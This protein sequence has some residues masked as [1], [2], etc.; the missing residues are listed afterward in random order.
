MRVLMVL[1][2]VGLLLL[3]GGALLVLCLS[4]GRDA[5][6]TTRSL[7]PLA[8]E[9][10]E[11]TFKPFLV[12]QPL[13]ELSKDENATV[14]AMVRK[15]VHYLKRTQTA[16]GTWAHE[17]DNYVPFAGLTLLEC[18]VSSDDPAIVRAADYA[19]GRAAH[20]NHTYAASLF[21]LFFDRLGDPRDNE[22]I[23]DLAMRL[24]AGQTGQGGWGYDVP[25]LSATESA[26]LRTFL[27]DSGR[28]TEATAR[29]AAA[30][31]SLKVPSRLRRL[32]LWHTSN[33]PNAEYFR[34]GG[35]NSNTQFALLALWAA[36]RHK[37]PV[38]PSLDLV[39]RRFRNS[40]NPDGS[41]PYEG[42]RF[43]SELPSMTCA[44]LLGLAV[45]YGLMEKSDVSGPQHDA[46]IQKALER[47][48]QA[49]GR[50]ANSPQ[51]SM[52]MTEMYFLWSLERVAVLYQ[53]KKIVDK[54]W[55]RWGFTML[56]KNQQGDGSW[57]AH[58]GHGTNPLVDTC[59]A[60]LF[61][62][63]A[64]LV[65]DLTDKLATLNASATLNSDAP[66]KDHP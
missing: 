33:N 2:S 56:R 55:Y 35:D 50:P 45:D 25:I 19:R 40:Q 7:S 20:I 22:R 26:A 29:R 16:E 60:L 17:P 62:Q 63:R 44:G 53:L 23:A 10:P 32:G 11:P 57:H 28:R 59:F 64:N 66:R 13:I 46:A 31:R 6:A 18:G 9:I 43:A 27:R 51:E 47:I 48:S 1:G 38:E 14:E 39:V 34:G 41:F 30:E 8:A 58:R 36:R 3:L 21:L 49:I 5:E 52:A 42:H 61:L 65:K 24:V 15:G 37:L 54:D 12:N 4:G